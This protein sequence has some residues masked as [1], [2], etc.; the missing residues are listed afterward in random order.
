MISTTGTACFRIDDAILHRRELQSYFAVHSLAGPFLFRLL[1]A[2]DGQRARVFLVHCPYSAHEDPRPFGAT[3]GE[4]G[5]SPTGCLHFD[6]RHGPESLE[7]SEHDAQFCIVNA[8]RFALRLCDWAETGR[9]VVPEDWPGSPEMR[10]H[11]TVT[12]AK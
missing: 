4:C 3:V 6:L 10:A 2:A 1:A 9:F 8:G 11:L 12:E 7:T 5:L